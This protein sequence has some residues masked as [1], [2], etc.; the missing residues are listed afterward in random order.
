MSLL[1]TLG[2][3]LRFLSW[4]LL[5]ELFAVACLLAGLVGSVVWLVTAL[6][7]RNIKFLYGGLALGA[8]MVAGAFLPSNGLRAH[9]WLLTHEGRYAKPSP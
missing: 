6:I 4:D 2:Y 1:P 7:T 9:L 8:F 5:V 3:L